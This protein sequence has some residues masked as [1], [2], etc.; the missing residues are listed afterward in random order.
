MSQGAVTQLQN[1]LYDLNSLCHV[2]GISSHKGFNHV[3]LLDAWRLLWQLDFNIV[4]VAD[5]VNHRAFRTND[6]TRAASLQ[7]HS[8]L[9]RII[10]VEECVSLTHDVLNGFESFLASTFW[11][12]NCKFTANFCDWLHTSFV[13]NHLEHRISW[14]TNLSTFRIRYIYAVHSFS[15]LIFFF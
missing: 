3:S 12:L 7:G 8:F 6:R 1:L 10:V 15:I 9:S 11:P 14:T 13:F 4:L 2:L 5:L